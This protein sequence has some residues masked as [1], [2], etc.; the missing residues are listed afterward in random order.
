MK[1]QTLFLLAVLT[2]GLCVPLTEAKSM[3]YVRAAA[4]STK[5]KTIMQSGPINPYAITI[6]SRSMPV[7]AVG[8]KGTV[9]NDVKVGSDPYAA[10][11]KNER[12]N[13][14]YVRPPVVKLVNVN[15]RLWDKIAKR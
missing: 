1:L 9:K 4:M 2:I 8:V 12:P 6:K 10:P 7:G 5:V 15:K 13:R 11:K 3:K 14:N